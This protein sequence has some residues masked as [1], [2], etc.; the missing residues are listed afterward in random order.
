MEWQPIETAPI[1]GT[2]VLL[3]YKGGK[4][5]CGE[6]SDANDFFPAFWFTYG[7]GQ[8]NPTHWMPLPPPPKDQA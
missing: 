1:D 5:S 8:C 2:S 7:E 4:V 3:C 6:Y